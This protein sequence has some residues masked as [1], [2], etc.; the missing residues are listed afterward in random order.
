MENVKLKTKNI[1]K[2]LIFASLF[3]TFALA[4]QTPPAPSAPKSAAIPAVKET[5]LANGLR[6][7][8][9]ERKGV[10][11]VTAEVLT[12]SGASNEAESKAGLANLT[13]SL[14]TK[15]TKT[16]T[17]TQIAEEIEFLGGSISSA[18]GWNNS[19]LVINSMS[20]KLD[21]AM[22]VM[23]DVALNPAFKPEEIDLLKSQTL[24]GLTYNLKQPGFLS[25]YV[26]SKYSF[27]EHPAGGT[28]ESVK[29]IT[30]AEIADFYR[31]N[32]LPN[33]SVLIF[34]GDI[35]LAKAKILAQKYFGTWKRVELAKAIGS[36]SI[37]EPLEEKPPI[38]DKIL[39]VDLPNSGQ[40]AVSYAKRVLW[41]RTSQTPLYF[42]SLVMNSVLGGG[43]SSRLNQE[44]R[45]KRGLSY[46]A[47]SSFSWRSSVHNFRA[48][49]QTKDVSAAEVAELVVKEVERLATEDVG[50]NEL[51]PRKQV[52][53]GNFN[54]N[55]ET[56]GGIVNAVG[57]LYS[58]GVSTRELNQY[59]S[60][61][62]G[63]MADDVKL[64]AFTNVNHGDI[65]I[66][67]DYAKFKDDLAKRFPNMK[68]EVVKADGLDLSKLGQ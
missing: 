56:T 64:Y 6:V 42:P 5:K 11:I 9:I 68:I 14:L 44:I 2:L 3:S 40:S 20:D 43:Y 58:L 21:K 52:L 51:I 27:G 25:S 26:A 45:I 65:I 10:P 63:V 50:E 17:A 29:S 1:L 32:Y 19:V 66:A 18:A 36:S 31:K 54:R 7:A 60:N 61:V 33:N 62:S 38:V 30:K 46:G 48:S 67:G 16:R 53:I 22:A 59:V 47:G 12:L 57:E 55:L 15:G 23:A 8:V 34:A 41:G 28:P 4:Q 13:A 39:V 49:A 35:S 24:D 37:R